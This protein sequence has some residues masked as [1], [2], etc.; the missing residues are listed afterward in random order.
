MVLLF[1]VLFVLWLVP[2]PSVV[3][4]APLSRSVLRLGCWD[5]GPLVT[6]LVI[7]GW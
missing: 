3:P 5:F 2:W 6:V 7:I 1:D 4:E